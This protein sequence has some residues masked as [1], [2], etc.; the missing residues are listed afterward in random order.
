MKNGQKVKNR[1]VEEILLP[2]NGA[3]VRREIELS[4]LRTLPPINL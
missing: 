2:S 4:E 1:D 3:Q